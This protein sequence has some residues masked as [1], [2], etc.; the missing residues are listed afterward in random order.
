MYIV[1]QK[2]VKADPRLRT[3]KSRGCLSVYAA[4][5][6]HRLNHLLQLRVI[7]S[8]VCRHFAFS[9]KYHQGLLLEIINDILIR[10][11]HYVFGITILRQHVS[12]FSILAFLYNRIIRLIDALITIAFNSDDDINVIHN[13]LIRTYRRI[14]R[15]FRQR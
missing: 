14:L 8:Y 7:Q 15:G 4:N 11:V 6:F 12:F 3:S 13:C 10:M 2:I 5:L 9:L 1:P